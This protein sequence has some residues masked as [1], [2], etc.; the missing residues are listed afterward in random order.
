MISRGVDIIN[1]IIYELKRL[2]KTVIVMEHRF[3]YLLDK[4]DRIYVLKDGVLHPV[5]ISQEL[6]AVKNRYKDDR[7]YHPHNSRGF[8]ERVLELDNVWFKYE[9]EPSWVLKGVTL[10]V[11]HGDTV[12]IY[13]RN[14]SGKSTLL[15][16]MAGIL[17]PTRGVRKI[18][19]KMLYVPQ[20]SYLFFTED[21]IMGEIQELCKAWRLGEDCINKA[22]EVLKSFG[23]DYIEALPLN[24]SWGQQTRLATLLA[25]SVAKNGILLLDEPFTGSTYIDSVNIVNTLGMLSDVTKIVT[26]SSRDYIALLRNARVYALDDGVLKPLVHQDNDI[27][28]GIKLAYKWLS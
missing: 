6:E 21:S 25:Y 13:G 20:V 23:F 17:R 26:V 3:M 11:C 10:N 27:V 15:R 7:F 18:H 4:V 12:V 1:S 28:E 14:G 19:R 16:I 22:V 9:D 5:T 8:C 2:N 24:L